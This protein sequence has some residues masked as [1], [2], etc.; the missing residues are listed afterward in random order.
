M[1]SEMDAGDELGKS[2]A[3]ER[4]VGNGGAPITAAPDFEKGRTP[5]RSPYAKADQFCS[6]FSCLS[7]CSIEPL[8]A[9]MTF[10]NFRSIVNCHTTAFLR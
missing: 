10:A 7:F 6:F 8:L 5:W 1:N 4:D 2:D 9:Q 3:E